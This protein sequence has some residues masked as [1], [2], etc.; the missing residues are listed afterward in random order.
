MGQNEEDTQRRLA[1]TVMMLEEPTAA[2]A[3]LPAP[4]QLIVRL[5]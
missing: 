2:M 5:I 1:I 4:E 3:T